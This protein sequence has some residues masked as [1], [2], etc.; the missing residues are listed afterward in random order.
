[1][2]ELVLSYIMCRWLRWAVLAVQYFSPPAILL[3]CWPGGWTGFTTFANHCAIVAG[4]AGGL[5]MTS[6]HPPHQAQ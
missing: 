4:C 2:L 5:V 6:C 1:M 3:Q